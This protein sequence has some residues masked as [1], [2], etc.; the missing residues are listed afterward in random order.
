VKTGAICRTP[1]NGWS[2]FVGLSACLIMMTAVGCSGSDEPPVG[3]VSGTV[4]YKDKP[5]E[6]GALY[7]YNNET[8]NAGGAEVKDGKFE[9]ATELK[10]GTYTVYVTAIPPPP[11]NPEN[12]PADLWGKFPEDVPEK[13]QRQD[14][15]DLK[16]E[17]K[18]GHTD[19]AIVIP[20]K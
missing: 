11:P 16:V 7:I 15:S 17:I 1:T 14:K 18:E 20:S 10:T 6:E 13:Y 8:A 3:T 2:I 5:L 4:T 9:I 19:V 12:P